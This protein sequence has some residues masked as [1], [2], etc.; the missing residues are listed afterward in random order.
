MTTYT[1]T[2]SP[3]DNKLRLYASTRLDAETYARVKAAGFI[4]APKQE[5]FVAPMW[6]PAREDIAL[7]LA[8][9]IEDDDSSLVARAEDRAERFDEYADKRAADAK[10][11]RDAVA[12]IADNIPLGQPI[13]V[14]HHS[15]RSARRD[16]ERIENGMRRAVKMWDTA[17][18][19]QSRAA[20]AVRAAKYK[21]R[22]DVRARRIKG[23]EADQ[24]KHTKDLK[25]ARGML[26][27]WST[28]ES[29]SATVSLPAGPSDCAVQRPAT[30]LEKALHVANVGG[31]SFQF[32]LADFPRDPPASQYEGPMSLWS[33]LKD[34]VIGPEK[35]RE[36]AMP[37]YERSA[38]WHERWLTHI[39]HRLDYERAMLADGGGTATTRTGPEKGGAVRCWASPK[40]GWSLVQ[41]VNKVSVSILHTWGHGAPFTITMP[42]DKLAAVM[43]AAQVAEAR[44]AGR[45]VETGDGIGFYL[46]EPPAPDDGQGAGQERQEDRAAAGEEAPPAPAALPA[47]AAATA[48]EFDAMRAALK[49]GMRVV[50][51]DQLVPTPP[52]LAAAVVDA[53]EI[54]PGHRV[55]EPSAGTGRL[56]DPLF[57]SEGTEWALGNGGELVAVEINSELA[58]ALRRQYVAATVQCADFLSIDPPRDPAAMFDRIIMN[59][60]FTRGVDVQHVQHAMRFLKPG[61]RLV[62]IMSNGLTFR[63]D[64]ATA[65]LRDCIGEMG[66]TIE[67]LPPGSFKASGTAVETVL[68][69]VEMIPEG[70]EA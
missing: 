12:R 41:K 19:W 45:V 58:K 10:A 17:S 59:P 69:V 8:G 6:T 40:G 43:T 37:A 4:W 24:R 9:E 44:A 47:P 60:P 29:R 63:Q 7:E 5:V 1:A 51:A 11:A 39:G 54:E 34:G 23:L 67:R 35:A 18:Y 57:N 36:L 3:D 25:H 15:E 28:L 30:Y 56:L 38:A 13:L 21:E 62:A 32:P 50:V 68:V 61:G 42:F 49:Q 64:R 66:G 46:R 26:A 52:D 20:G 65:A 2:Y 33:A 48:E 14:G 53:A 22:P 27:L 70:A 55:L 31:I 16:A